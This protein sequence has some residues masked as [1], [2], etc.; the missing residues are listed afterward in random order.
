MAKLNLLSPSRSAISRTG[1]SSAPSTCSAAAFGALGEPIYPS[2]SSRV[3]P[4]SAIAAR[5]ASIAKATMLRSD[6]RSMADDPTPMKA[7]FES[8]M[9]AH[10]PPIASTLEEPPKAHK[11]DQALVHYVHQQFASARLAVPARTVFRAE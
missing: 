11:D 9:A 8:V 10:V 6:R 7:T 5:A 4:A 1:I 3:R 2:I